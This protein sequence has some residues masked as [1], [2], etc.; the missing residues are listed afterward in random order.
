MV[1]LSVFTDRF[2]QRVL[3]HL[4]VRQGIDALLL[5]PPRTDS[6]VVEAGEGVHFDVRGGRVGG[7][8]NIKFVNVNI[9]KL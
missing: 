2:G 5:P 7:A 4:K 6:G 3:V 8:A 1:H 9:K